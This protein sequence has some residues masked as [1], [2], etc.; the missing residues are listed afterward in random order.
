MTVREV[1]DRAGITVRALHHYDQIG[2]LQ[3]GSV[4]EAGYRIYDEASLERL[5]RILFLR[6][7]GF[8]LRDIARMLDNPAFDREAALI[9][10]HDLLLL[11][12]KRL[13]RLIA[14]VEQAMKGE[15][16]M[17]FEALNT[18][19]IDQYKEEAKA[20]WGETAAWAQSEARAK[21]RGKSDWDA[22]NAEREAIFR[23]FA[24]C[25]EEGG[26]P[27]GCVEAW[28]T[29]IN[30]HFYDCT[31]EILRSLAVMYTEDERF[32][33]HFDKVKPG[34]AAYIAEAIRMHA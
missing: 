1:A 30:R 27:A 9:E 14:L 20:R 29:H 25:M 31:P 32:Q 33:K 17:D 18:Q 12:R 11:Q 34:L 5:W 7:L 23:Q 21:K 8:P 15:T 28:R 26:D 3:P 24:T 22:I 13:D 6:E 2:L 19:E 4:T 10:H 16:T